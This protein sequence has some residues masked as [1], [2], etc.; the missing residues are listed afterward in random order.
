LKAYL[1]ETI[2]NILKAARDKFGGAE[3]IEQP[4]LYRYG[5]SLDN[6]ELALIYCWIPSGSALVSDSVKKVQRLLYSNTK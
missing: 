4:R 2:F 5:I 3:Y 6:T 1:I